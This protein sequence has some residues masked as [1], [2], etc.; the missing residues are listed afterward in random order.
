VGLALLAVSGVGRM[1]ETRLSNVSVRT[2]AGGTDTLIT[3]FTIGPGAPKSVLIRAV[4]P[5]LDGFGVTGTL[6]DPKLELYNSG[7]VKIVEND[8]F[9]PADAPTF[10]SVGAFALNAGARDAALVITLSPG[11]YTAQVT[12]VGGASGVALVEVYELS[13]GNPRLINL[14]TR[15]QVGT[16]GNILIPGLTIASGTGTR[17]LLLRAIGPTLA[18]FGVSGTLNDPRLELYAGATKV[19]ENDNWGIPVGSGVADA[20][21]LTAA[22][23][24][25]GAFALT[26]GSRD[27]ALLIELAAGSYT[28]QVS[29][30]GNTT[31]TALVEIYD[32]A[33]PPIISA[34]PQSLTLTAG[35]A[36]S[37]AVV[38]AGPELAYQWFKDGASLAAARSATLLLTPVQAAS[39]GTYSVTVTNPGGSIT[40]AAATVTV[41]S[42][43]TGAKPSSALYLAYLRPETTATGSLVSGYA[44]LRI[45]ADS[46]AT[47]NISFSNLSSPLTASH[48]VIGAGTS[49]FVLN[50]PLTQVTD[51][52]WFFQPAGTFT[53]NDLI[54][55]LN[56][57]NIFIA[58]DTAKFP[59]GEVRA[60]FRAAT[61]SQTFTAP[62]APPALPAGLLSTPAEVDAAR[63]LIQATFGPTDESI[64]EVKRLGM[65]S[66]IH[67]QLAIPATSFRKVIR[68]EIALYPTP[69]IAKMGGPQAIVTNV[70]KNNSW[71]TLA[72]EAPD[73][74]RQR[75]GFALS[76]IFAV[77]DPN[78]TPLPEEINFFYDNLVQRAFG[79][80]RDLLE[81]VSLSP[82]MAWNLTFMRNRKADPIK[83]TSPDE[84]YAREVQQL[85]TIG[86][87][88]LQPDGTLLVDRDGKPIPTYDNDTIT[89]TAKVFTGWAYQNQSDNFLNFPVDFASREIPATRVPV[90][91]IAWRKCSRTTA[92]GFAAISGRS[93]A[94]FC[95]T[96][97]RARRRSRPTKATARSRS[98][99]SVWQRF[100]G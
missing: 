18:G 36:G 19:A 48:L 23:A 98:R 76:E 2:A 44:S 77:T 35:A 73:Q 43:Q 86:L 33:A 49:N 56:A 45:D 64:A 9:N 32:L 25:S 24:R 29:G 97:R 78:G 85:F 55:A 90:M 21:T 46:S 16:G 94:R 70:N 81:F 57:G 63:L 61:G 26:A 59:A 53:T 74:L 22:F 100:G 65:D 1:Q 82:V 66:W 39:A 69:E 88:Q 27:A 47:L 93:S 30:V 60:S 67:A 38:A 37:L 75:A 12:G 99:S 28:L 7:G 14:S 50:L 52:T 72:V 15:A 89:E 54:T 42:N 40:S 3:G 96:T 20:V 80:Y 62:A 11:S 95:W 34:Q 68:D 6:T 13:G 4:G 17:R 10:A 83:G 5:T 41:Q 92:A 79:N 91:F 71:W 31:G 51:A 84:N 8:N 58:L 87:V